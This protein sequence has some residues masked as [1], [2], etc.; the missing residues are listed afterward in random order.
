[1]IRVFLLVDNDCAFSSG[2][3]NTLGRRIIENIIA[4]AHCGDLRNH[5]PGINV[6]HD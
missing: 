1:M 4:I 6:E 3:V 2:R 5:G